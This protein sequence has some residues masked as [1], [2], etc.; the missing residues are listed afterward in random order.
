MAGAAVLGT[1]Y[2]GFVAYALAL[3]HPELVGKLVMMDSP[4]GVYRPEDY[5]ALLERHEVDDP[6]DLFVPSD[7]EGVER[8]VA[9]AYAD[10]RR[11]WSIPTK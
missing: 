4:G 1:S 11:R 6:L 2:G 8:L 3:R 7:P 10:P 5:A 9:L